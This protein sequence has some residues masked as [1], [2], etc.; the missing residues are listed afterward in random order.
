[1]D[2]QGNVH[3]V[4][5]DKQNIDTSEPEVYDKYIGC[6]VIMDEG[7]NGGGNLVTVKNRATDDRGHA[8]GTAHNN[9]MI[10]TR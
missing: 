6:R 10:D 4:D 2:A 8:L 7:V 3:T 1:M 5:D 9:Q